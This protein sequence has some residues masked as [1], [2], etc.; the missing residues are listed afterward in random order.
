MSPEVSELL[1]TKN[2]I[3]M[4]ILNLTPDSFSDGMPAASQDDFLQ[5]A[6]KLISEGCHILDVGGESTRPGAMP[7]SVKEECDRV[8]PFLEL[9]RKKFPDFPVSLDTRKVE[10]A[11]AA[12]AFDYQILNDTSC[13]ADERFLKLCLDHDL[14]YVLMHSRGTPQT[15]TTLANYPDGLL[16]TLFKELQ[17]Q[18]QKIA[19]FSIRQDRV[20][21]DPGF[22]F[23]KTPEQC[24]ELMGSLKEWSAFHAPL[25]FGVSRKRFLQLLSGENLPCDRDGLTAELSYKAFAKG[26]QILRIHNVGLTKKYFEQRDAL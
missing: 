5:K 2:P 21:I 8:L 18:L 1:K 10:V 15:M 17:S 9:F 24:L 16:K 19:S 4:G 11:Q 22:G 6:E 14:Y 7:V 13:L 12:L 3:F 20:I 26:F 25:L 23:A